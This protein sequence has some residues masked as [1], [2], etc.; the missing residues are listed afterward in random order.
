MWPLPYLVKR[1]WYDVSW[2]TE[3]ALVPV[4][5]RVS[6]PAEKGDRCTEHDF[7]DATFRVFGM[8]STLF[9]DLFDLDSIFVGLL[10]K[11]FAIRHS[12]RK[13]T[14]HAILGYALFSDKPSPSSYVQAVFFAWRHAPWFPSVAWSSLELPQERGGDTFADYA[15]VEVPQ[16]G[17]EIGEPKVGLENNRVELVR[18]GLY[19]GYVGFNNVQYCTIHIN[20]PVQ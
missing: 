6:F 7:W 15:V 18:W 17:S 19:V 16:R 8:A 2:K 3:M 9:I 4:K 11:Q 12:N 5:L 1:C 20:Q 10:Q 13:H 14:K